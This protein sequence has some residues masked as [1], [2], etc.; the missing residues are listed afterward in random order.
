MPEPVVEQT[1]DNLKERALSLFKNDKVLIVGSAGSGK[2]PRY[3]ADFPA[4]AIGLD[5]DEPAK[6]DVLGDALFLPFTDESVPFVYCEALLE[7]VPEPQR[8]VD[9]VYRALKPGGQAFFYVPFLYPYHES[10]DD[11]FRFTKSGMAYLCRNF[12]YMQIQAA[13]DGYAGVSMRF[14]VGFTSPVG[15][16]LSRLVRYPAWWCIAT[17]YST[18]RLLQG[19]KTEL[20]R[21][22]QHFFFENCSGFNVLVKK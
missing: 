3:Q 16:I 5:I 9:E 21:V 22:R 14:L 15:N 4:G 6:P 1:Q 20:A 7:H 19:R 8:V 18:V 17:A 12:S 11:Y 2:M 13:N 10:P